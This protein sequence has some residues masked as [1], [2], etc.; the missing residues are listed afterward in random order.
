M[1]RDGIAK[2]LAKEPT[3][4]QQRRTPGYRNGFGRLLTDDATAEQAKR[5]Q[6]AALRRD[7]I[8]AAISSRTCEFDVRGKPI[9][10]LVDDDAAIEQAWQ[11]TF[12]EQGDG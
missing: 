12:G 6:L 7:R 10:P 5:S 2:Y 8:K 4:A 1:A 11:E 3:A 9:D